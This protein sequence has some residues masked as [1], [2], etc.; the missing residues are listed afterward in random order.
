MNSGFVR[1]ERAGNGQM[2]GYGWLHP[3]AV[4]RMYHETADQFVQSS[5]QGF[6][7]SCGSLSGNNNGNLHISIKKKK[8]EIQFLLYSHND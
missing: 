3:R 5:A 7:R 6:Y 4:Q 1:N 8:I 2:R